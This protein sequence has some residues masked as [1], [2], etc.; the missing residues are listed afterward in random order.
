MSQPE[1]GI[2]VVL[3]KINESMAGKK[4]RLVGRMLWYEAMSGLVALVDGDRAVLVDVSL[5]ITPKS[6]WV[7][8]YLCQ[9]VVLGH[10]ELC[11]VSHLTY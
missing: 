10:L 9:L 8:E 7:Q 3:R 11:E 2:P 6:T 4:L 5:C 1:H